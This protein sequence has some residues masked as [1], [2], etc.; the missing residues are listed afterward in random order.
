MNSLGFVRGWG[1]GAKGKEKEGLA[2]ACGEERA[3]SAVL[4]QTS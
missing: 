1:G 4:F 3:E 2:W